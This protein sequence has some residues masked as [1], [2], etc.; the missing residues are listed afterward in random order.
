MTI[1]LDGIVLHDAEILVN[2]LGSIFITSTNQKLLAEIIDLP[3]QT[4]R[5]SHIRTVTWTSGT[6][7]IAVAERIAISW[8]NDGFKVNRIDGKSSTDKLVQSF[9]L[10]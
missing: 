9:I 6:D 5:L 7:A 3:F 4:A 1:N 8:E 10:V 2:G